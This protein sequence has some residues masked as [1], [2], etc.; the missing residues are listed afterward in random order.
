MIKFF[1]NSFFWKALNICSSLLTGILLARLLSVEG[2]G[3]YAI[4]ISIISFYTVILNFGIPESLVYLLNKEKDNTSTLVKYGLLI[5]TVILLKLLVLYSALLFLDINI[6]YLNISSIVTPVFICLIFGSYNVLLRHLI[7]KDNNI[8]I[9][10]LLSSIETIF[11]LIIFFI[12]YLTNQFTLINIIYVFTATILISFIIHVVYL[13]KQLRNIFLT[14]F[15]LDFKLFRRL[16]KLS[17]PLFFV[18]L[19]GIFSTRLNLFLLD[20]FHGSVSVGYFAIAIIFPNL[21]LII[22]NQ[23]SALLY[24]VASGIKDVEKLII[25]GNNILKYVMFFTLILVIIGGL[26]VPFLIPFFYGEKYE[27]VI[28]TVYIIL[29]GILFGGINSVLLNLLISHGKS[30]VLLYNALTIMLGIVLFSFLVYLYSY[31]GTAFTFTIINFICFSISFSKYKKITTFKPL[32]LIIK[33]QDIKHLQ[34]KL[35]SLLRK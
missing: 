13:K 15:E 16:L 24:P 23:I 25:Y 5:P 14:N 22:P 3:E 12:L 35:Y 11:N 1:I 34:I 10:N 4:F 9:Y 19:S 17:I 18:G 7:L 27:V 2:R 6:L 29:I 32:S 28:P 26:V 33:W 21:L 20:Y 8:P 30:K 31:K